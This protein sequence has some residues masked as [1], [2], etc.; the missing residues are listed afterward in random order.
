MLKLNLYNINPPK[1]ISQKIL[2]L[3]DDDDNDD[4]DYNKCNDTEEDEKEEKDGK[5]KKD[6]HKNHRNTYHFHK[7]K[8][9]YNSHKTHYKFDIINTN[10]VLISN[11]NKTKERTELHKKTT[12]KESNTHFNNIFLPYKN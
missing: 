9:N 11:R 3:R 8:S 2:N 1:K 12:R 4:I 10:E 5:H 6:I 7:R